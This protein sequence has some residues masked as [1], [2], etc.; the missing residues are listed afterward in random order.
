MTKSRAAWLTARDVTETDR[1]ED[2][3]REV[4]RVGA[5]EGMRAEAVCR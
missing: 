1:G 2:S 3:D 4:Q 5:G